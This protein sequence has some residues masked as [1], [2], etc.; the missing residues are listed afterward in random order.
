MRNIKLFLYHLLFHHAYNWYFIGFCIM[1][2]LDDIWWLESIS[3]VVL[4]VIILHVIHKYTNLLC[5]G[6]L[7]CSSV[8][9]HLC[10]DLLCFVCFK[11]KSRLP[12][13]FQA[14]F[15]CYKVRQGEQRRRLHE[16]KLLHIV[17]GP[18]SSMLSCCLTHSV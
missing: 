2:F 12:H 1:C 5:V 17:R 13:F 10:I 9:H 7:C 18:C 16:Q 8:Y 3:I 6:A 11:R 15:M 4:C 14:H